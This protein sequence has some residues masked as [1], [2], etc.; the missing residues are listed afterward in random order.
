[1]SVVSN[2]VPTGSRDIGPVHQCNSPVICKENVPLNN[3]VKY[4]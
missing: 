4:N 1:M 2:T 3:E